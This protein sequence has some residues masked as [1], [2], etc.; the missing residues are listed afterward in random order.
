MSKS[1]CISIPGKP[2]GKGRPRFSR[3]GHTYTPQNTADYEDLI[4]S[5]WYSINGC[6]KFT[7]DTPLAC[8]ITAY[9]EP[10]KSASK[11]K[12]KELLDGLWAMKK[13]DADN[14]VKVVLDALNGVAYHDDVQ[15][16]CVF[17]FKKY[18]EVAS[19]DVELYEVGG[20]IY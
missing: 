5:V 4:K 3:N 17:T 7:L 12:R 1:Y 9:Y 6:A 11:K 8:R 15:V 19:V 16:V 14:I 20:E 2:Q 13:P 10:P 18:A